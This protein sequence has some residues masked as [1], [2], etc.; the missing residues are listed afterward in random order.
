M[1]NDRSPGNSTLI[2]L[3]GILGPIIVAVIYNWKTIFP[4][5]QHRTDSATIEPSPHPPQN[6]HLTEEIDPSTISNHCE[7]IKFAIQEIPHNFTHLIGSKYVNSDTEARYDSKVNLGPGPTK[8]IYDRQH[9]YYRLNLVLYEGSS[10]EQADENF[11]SFADLLDQCIPSAKKS[12]LVSGSFKSGKTMEY[13][14]ETSE[15]SVDLTYMD[16]QNGIFSVD[17]DVTN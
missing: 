5:R 13:N 15:Y 11:K 17:V 9:K 1:A 4:E 14:Y 6:T 12:D 3:I 7:L 16:A 8:I 2:A 10:V